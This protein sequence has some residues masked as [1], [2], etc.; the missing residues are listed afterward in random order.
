MDVIDTTKGA[1]VSKIVNLAI[2][3]IVQSVLSNCYAMNDFLFVGRIADGKLAAECTSAI[4]ATVGLQI[5]CFAFHNII[6]SGSN[7]YSAQY[8]GANNTAGLVTTFRSG[9]YGSLLVSVLLSIVGYIFIDE[10]ALLTNS[11]PEVTAQVKT[12]FGILITSSP[13][14]GLLLMVDGFYKSNGDART[15]LGLEL[16]S[17]FLNTVGNYLFVLHFNWGIAGAAYASALSR[18]LPAI[19]GGYMLLNGRLGIQVSLKIQSMQM[20]REVVYMISKLG[21]LGIFE[22]MSQ[23]I[24]GYVFT[25]LI[26]LSGDLGPA[27]QAGLGAGMRGLEWISFTVSEGFLVAAMTSVGQNIG[28]DFQ[29]RAMQ[30]ALYCV[31]LSTVLAGLLGVPFLTF[32]EKI[33]A[34]LGDDPDIVKYCSQYLRMCGKIMAFIGFEMA[35]Y[36]AFIGAGKARLVF[37]INSTMNLLRIPITVLGMYGQ[38]IHALAWAVGLVP[39]A[40]NDTKNRSANSV[41][42]GGVAIPLIGDF[43][44]VCFAIAITG[45]MKAISFGLILAHRYYSNLLF[46]DSNLVS[47]ARDDQVEKEVLLLDDSGKADDV[48]N[49]NQVEK[50]SETCRCLCMSCE[51]PVD[52]DEEDSK[53]MV[54]PKVTSGWG[55]ERRRPRNQLVTI[56]EEPEE[57]IQMTPIHIALDTKIS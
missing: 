36:G 11:T 26:R 41:T 15:P 17:L 33:S 49:Q 25:I 27:Q 34:L 57:H 38:S 19:L 47:R 5:V 21:K 50:A 37:S 45:I 10:I 40:P 16:M 7:A 39:R 56:V 46:R 42:H 29:E 30:A 3:S 20:V 53:L 55:S 24:Y 18:L 51:E 28:A 14:F 23:F 43:D 2:P 9:I 32:P 44:A 22:S 54:V 35:C 13:A 31:F 1:L 4:S 12:Y 48:E 6:P 8:R 52:S